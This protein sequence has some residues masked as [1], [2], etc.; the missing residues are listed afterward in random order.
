MTADVVIPFHGQTRLLQR[1][2]DALLQNNIDERMAIHLVNDGT[3]KEEMAQVYEWL[4]RVQ[5]RINLLQL[6][7]QSG[8]VHAVNHAWQ[9]C[10]A[11][12]FIILNNDTVPAPGLMG[13]LLAVLEKDETLAAV[14]PASNNRKDLFQYRGF[15]P[16]RNVK[17]DQPA[18][19]YSDYLTAACLAVKRSAAGND[20]LFDPIY[21]PGYFEDLDL[22]CRLM[23]NGWKLAILEQAGMFHEGAATFG[24]KANLSEMIAA[25]HITYS[26]RWGHLPGHQELELL[27]QI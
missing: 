13:E 8:F 5:H 10:T 19:S 26:K 12:V 7:R 2:V 22:C 21:T 15:I 25:N 24:A 23:Q 11:D 6:N 9:L 14:A 4:N 18:Y 27:L 3:P 20:E 17:H 1:C 16:V